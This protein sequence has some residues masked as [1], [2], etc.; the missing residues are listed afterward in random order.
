MFCLCGRCSFV[1]ECSRRDFLSHV[2]T[3]PMKIPLICF[4]IAFLSLASSRALAQAAAADIV[5]SE[6]FESTPVGQ[7]PKGFTKTGAIGVAEDAAHSGK[8][9]LKIEPAEKGGRF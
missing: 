8:H 4:F 6:D 5:V 9:S 2:I 7:I 1:A 3:R